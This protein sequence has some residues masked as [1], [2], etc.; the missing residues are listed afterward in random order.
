MGNWSPERA[1]Q[2]AQ[3]RADME[4]HNAEKDRMYPPLERPC[5]TPG[6]VYTIVAEGSELSCSVRL[7]FAV[8]EAVPAEALETLK[9][10]VHDTMLPLVEQFYRDVWPDTLAGRCID[11]DDDPLPPTWTGLFFKWLDRCVARGEQPTFEGRIIWSK[12]SVFNL[13]QDAD[14]DR[15]RQL[16]KASQPSLTTH[17]K[18]RLAKPAS[19]PNTK[20][21]ATPSEKKP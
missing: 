13:R 19:R 21:P 8:E 1:R 15:R 17:G 7:P 3:M 14:S 16:L 6:A 4:R 10:A 20:T 2:N 9:K 12:Q 18:A 11:G 5:G